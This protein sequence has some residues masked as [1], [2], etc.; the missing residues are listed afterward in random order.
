MQK[1]FTFH[2]TQQ[3][4]TKYAHLREQGSKCSEE[5]LGLRGFIVILDTPTDKVI[6]RGGFAPENNEA[7]CCTCDGT[8]LKCENIID[9]LR[10]RMSKGRGML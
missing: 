5:R 2:L 8:D 7:K 4:K 9:D 1:K 10:E 3:L 6:C